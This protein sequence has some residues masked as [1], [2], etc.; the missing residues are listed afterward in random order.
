MTNCSSG[1]C[2]ESYECSSKQIFNNNNENELT[3]RK[4]G[5][6]KRFSE[7]K[8]ENSPKPSSSQPESNSKKVKANI[9]NAK[10]NENMAIPNNPTVTNQAQATLLTTI[11]H[12]SSDCYKLQGEFRSR[13]WNVAG[14]NILA[15]SCWIAKSQFLY[16]RPRLTGLDFI[17]AA[18]I[19]TACGILA[20]LFSW[21]LLELDT[22]D[23]ILQATSLG[24]ENTNI[25]VPID[26]ET[27]STTY[28][29][30][31]L[32]GVLAVVAGGAYLLCKVSQWQPIENII[33]R[34]MG[35]ALQREFVCD[36]VQVCQESNI[37]PENMEEL[38]EVSERTGFQELHIAMLDFFKSRLK[39][40]E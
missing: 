4:S 28:Y 1:D 35:R 24:Q 13:G 27:S 12:D 40:Q 15:V 7:T 9:D 29:I 25:E 16:A 26:R 21:F 14:A 11:E 34:Q 18:M 38:I 31:P 37:D 6:N 8:L 19:T 39:M 36:L 10:M 3:H 23:T 32:V 17:I 33:Q 22:E 2:E 30:L 5:E 20:S